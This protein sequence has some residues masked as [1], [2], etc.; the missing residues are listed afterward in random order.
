MRLFPVLLIMVSPAF[1]QTQPAYKESFAAYTLSKA[2]VAVLTKALDVADG[3]NRPQ[4]ERRK[5]VRAR[6]FGVER[7][8]ISKKTK[9]PV[10]GYWGELV[11][12]EGCGRRWSTGSGFSL[13][14]E[15]LVRLRGGARRN[16]DRCLSNAPCYET[17]FPRHTTGRHGMRHWTIRRHQGH[18]RRQRADLGGDLDRPYLR[19]S[20]PVPCDV[21]A[22]VGRH[23]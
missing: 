22:T 23:P 18:A 14:Q 19:H 20:P 10:A 21:R 8:A 9:Q 12:V 11:S 15:I 16:P 4:C 6:D 3:R 13:R 2:C 7:L 5:M 17:G 1:A